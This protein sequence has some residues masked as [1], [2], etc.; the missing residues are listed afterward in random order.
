[1]TAST[2]NAMLEA[3]LG[4]HGSA[5]RPQIDADTR[6]AF[7]GLSPSPALRRVFEKTDALSFDSMQLFDLSDFIDVNRHPEQLDE[8]GAGLFFADDLSDGYFFIDQ[9][10]FMGLGSGFVFWVSRGGLSVDECIPVAESFMNFLELAEQG[11]APWDTAPTLGERAI[12]RLGKLLVSSDAVECRPAID[13]EHLQQQSRDRTLPVP[14]ALGRIW[15]YADGFLLIDSGREFFGI[16]KTEPVIGTRTR[17][18]EP[19]A[20]WI[21]NEPGGVRYATTVGLWG[22]LPPDRMIAVNSDQEIADGALL[23]RTADVWTRWILEDQNS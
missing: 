1:M 16:E 19:G 14:A 3:F 5:F 12:S 20:L 13:P 9:D 7:L 23:G 11:D 6:Q 2:D 10:D 21:G 4:R 18:D 17:I 8:V 15:A 22:D